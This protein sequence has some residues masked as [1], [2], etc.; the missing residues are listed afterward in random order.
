M[1]KKTTRPKSKTAHRNVT[2]VGELRASRAV[3]AITPAFVDWCR[4]TENV[5]AEDALVLLG[6]V[7]RLVAAYFH[8][9]PA[10]AATN[11]E[12]APFGLA[13][14][15]ILS[16]P[17][18]EE[19]WAGFAFDAIHV[20]LEFLSS[21]DAWTGT[22]EDFEAVDDLFHVGEEG[23]LPQV[24]VPNL[25]DQEE[26][27]GLEGT[28]LAQRMEALLTWIGSGKDV[29]STG[30]L[31]LKDIEGAAAAV[32]VAAK[33]AKANA[34]REQ[35]P[36]FSLEHAPPGHVRTVKSMRELPLL[37]KFWVALDASGLVDIGS[38]KVWPTPLAEEFLEPGHPLR[39][40]VLRVFTTKFLAIS[41]MGE[42]EWAPWVTQAAMAQASILFAACAQAP[43]PAGALSDP[44]KLQVLDLDEYG[45]RLLRERMAELAELG[46]VTMEGIIAVPPAVVHSIVAVVH[47]GF[48]DDDSWP[49]EKV[50]ES[51]VAK[52]KRRKSGAPARL[53]QLKVMLKGSK[54]PI[55][56]RLVL[57]SDLTLDQM[58]QVLQLS[59][60]W[61]DSHLHEFQV[62][63]YNGTA[64]GPV[65]PEFDF[66]DPM[67]LDESAVEIGELLAAEKDAITYVYDFGDDW[68]HTVTLEK[69]L[70]HDGG[71]PAVRCTGGRGAGPAEDCGGVWGWESMVEAVNDPSHERHG[72]LRE[73]LMLEPGEA[74]DPTA[75]DQGEV[76]GRLIAS[77]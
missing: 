37:D 69:V 51:S 15:A 8:A 63:G 76:N 46:L 61:M 36:F 3:D 18:D 30:A 67:P 42:A 54:P 31:R 6:P 10:A 34:K 60:G 73:W 1:A 62:G 35:L 9:S 64:Y 55:W 32:G 21:T 66:G 2:S 58:H 11:F 22:D 14:D 56:R 43:V 72:E 71:V 38:T 74:L 39:R 40:A 17:D 75:F 16:E 20:Y 13:M 23:E 53:L 26:L 28:V 29:T 19:D 24:T 77:F 50:P 47:A 57:R 4:E 70:P 52:L 49:A 7:K 27:A 65:G 25:S 44:D 48:P 12:P 41:I 33:G 68:Q 45:A 59:F 5:P